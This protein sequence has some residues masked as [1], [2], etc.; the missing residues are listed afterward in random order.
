MNSDD[1][2]TGLSIAF[3][4]IVVGWAVKTI[5]TVV[6][7]PEIFVRVVDM[8]WLL[9]WLLLLGR[10]IYLVGDEIGDKNGNRNDKWVAIVLLGSIYLSHFYMSSKLMPLKREFYSGQRYALEV[11][12]ERNRVLMKHGYIILG[13]WD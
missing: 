3:V 9:A 13:Q 2:G 1:R 4:L 10:V 12:E 7:S 11:V 8:L 5:L 6:L